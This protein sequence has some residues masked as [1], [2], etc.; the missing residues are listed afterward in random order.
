LNSAKLLISGATALLWSLACAQG[1]AATRK[2]SVFTTG[3]LKQLNP[4]RKPW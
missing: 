1:F 2:E 4:A 3:A